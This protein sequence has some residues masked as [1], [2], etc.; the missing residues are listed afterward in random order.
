MKVRF[1]DHIAKIVAIE[2]LTSS[3][4]SDYKI[5][6]TMQLWDECKKDWVQK[7]DKPDKEPI[8]LQVPVQKFW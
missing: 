7:N 8:T 1:T 2:Q 4:Y 5:D 6:L 3:N